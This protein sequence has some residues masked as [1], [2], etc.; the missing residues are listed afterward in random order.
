MNTR[1]SL[2]MKFK[3]YTFLLLALNSLIVLQAKGQCFENVLYKV[4][5]EQK[6]IEI[7]F[8]KSYKQVEVNLE[9][10]WLTGN[11]QFEN[12]IKINNV[13]AG[14][15]YTV[16]ENL[17]PSKYIIQLKSDDCTSIVGGFD[18]IIIKGEDEG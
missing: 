17:R 10:V 9:D 13:V 2:I 11:D 6:G 7:Q 18:G 3:V 1:V 16:F 8:T 12:T 14:L 4:I 15:K 5:Q